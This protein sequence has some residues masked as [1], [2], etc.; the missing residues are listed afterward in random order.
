[1]FP[2]RCERVRYRQYAATVLDAG[3]AKHVASQFP[4]AAS[5][6]I[7]LSS[8]G[9]EMARRSRV[10]SASRSLRRF[11]WSLFSPPNSWRNR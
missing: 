6:R 4:R 10:F 2:A 7:S 3:A 5:R 8:V 9:A 1:M 11:T